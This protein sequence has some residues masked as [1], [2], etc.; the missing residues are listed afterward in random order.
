MGNWTT[1]N[2]SGTCSKEDLPALRNAIN[3]GDDWDKFHCLCNSGGLCGLGDWSGENIN[4]TGNLAERDYDQYDVA[5]ELE[6]LMNIAPSL[7]VKVHVGADY[8]SIKCVATVNCA[9]DVVTID[10]P[11]IETLDSI[12]DNQ[13]Q[14]NLMEALIRK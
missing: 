9:D 13:I 5:E 1:V 4:A 2:I 8:E 7:K 12:P 6:N 10:D 14:A 11:E 3:I